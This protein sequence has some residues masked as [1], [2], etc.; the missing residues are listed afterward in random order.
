[1]SC[2][3][4]PLVV[5]SPLAL[6]AALLLAGSLTA[7][8][9]I[10]PPHALALS[11][12]PAPG[13]PAGAKFSSFQGPR[14]DAAGRSLFYGSAVGGGVTAL[15]DQGVFRQLGAGL[16]LVAREGQLAPG[17]AGAMFLN[18][19]SGVINP[20][21]LGVNSAGALVFTT[22]LIGGDVCDCNHDGLLDNDTALYREVGGAL[23]L[24]ARADGQ[25]PGQ[26]PGLSFDKLVGQPLIADD[27]TLVFFAVITGPGVTFA[28]SVVFMTAAEGQPLSVVVRDGDPMPGFPE[29]TVIH[30]PGRAFISPTGE[31]SFFT[32][33]QGPGITANDDDVLLAFRDGALELVARAGDVLASGD[34]LGNPFVQGAFTNHS[35]RGGDREAFSSLLADDGSAVIRAL[36]AGLE[37]VVR[38]GDAA[39][40]L[41]PGTTFEK[42]GFFVNNGPLQLGDDGSLVF[43]GR[44]NTPSPSNES[45][46]IC[47][48]DGALHLLAR[49]GE[50]PPGAPPGVSFGNGSGGLVPLFGKVALEPGGRMAFLASVTGPGLDSLSKG[51]YA[52]D[53]AGTLHALVQPGDVLDVADAGTDLRTV[54]TAGFNQDAF[55][56]EAYNG[57]VFAANGA[58]VCRITFTD[59]SSGV[60]EFDLDDAFESLGGG[61]AGVAGVPALSGAGTLFA[62]TPASLALAQAA[63][64]APAL[65]L[66][67]VGSS[68]VPFKGGTLLAFPPL[69][70]LGLVT[71]GSGGIALPFVT[72]SGLPAAIDLTL[73]ALVLDAAAVNG[74]A[75]SNGLSA[76]TP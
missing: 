66:V 3:A 37:E 74:V 46:W 68:P 20:P 24:M 29:G 5:R 71:N 26:A 27:G 7:H 13:F 32:T 48:P 72:P 75:L 6:A 4:L 31:F 61:L 16:Q 56:L 73:Q 36:G 50:T 58:L 22:R 44:L 65:L 67:S 52:T 30:S 47:D 12:Q 15:T 35:E 60:F 18:L 8:A 39:P 62:S 70:Q 63:P 34:V 59:G 23:V 54:V 2:P 55:T 57:P 1:M 11:G 21:A 28:N 45:L 10:A 19:A 64:G 14:L 17:T 38:S 9:Q 43:M 41:P 49:G 33:L 53:A 69:V 42:F 76:T 25:V 51:L 40:G